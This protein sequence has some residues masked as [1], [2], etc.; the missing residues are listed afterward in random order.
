MLE[1]TN[2]NHFGM[3]RSEQ[4]HLGY[5]GVQKF[6]AETGRY[7]ENT[8]DDLDK[9]VAHAKAHNEEMKA[10]EKMHVEELD[11][12]IVKN[13]AAYCRCSIS[14]IC[15]FMGGFVAQEIVKFTGKYSP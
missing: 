13:V 5:M 12:S 3:Q 11:E 4:I 8:A 14:P 1:P 10:A 2:M 15:A 7:P 6:R 9:V